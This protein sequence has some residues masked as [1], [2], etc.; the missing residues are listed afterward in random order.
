MPNIL[1][2][3]SGNSGRSDYSVILHRLFLTQLRG[4]WS[5]E[6]GGKSGSFANGRYIL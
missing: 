5:A 1:A 6:G 3:G 2:N 4:A